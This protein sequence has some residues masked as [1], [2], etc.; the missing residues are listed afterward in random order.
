[1]KLSVDEKVSALRE[2]TKGAQD[3]FAA[4]VITEKQGMER[5]RPVYSGLSDS[6]IKLHLTGKMEIG[7]YPMMPDL[8]WPKVYW[9]CA[10]FDGKKEDTNWKR[11]VQ[12]ALEF[13]LDFDGCPCFV[14]LSRSGQGAHIRMLFKEAVPAWMARR[15]LQFWL[16][17]AGIIRT[18]DEEEYWDDLPPSF[19]R[20]I[21]PQDI[22]SSGLT[23]EGMRRPGNL[24]GA[25]LNGRHARSHGGTM[26]LDPYK[27]A[28]GNFE[29]DGKHW[30]HVM[31]ALEKRDWGEAQLVEA[32]QDCPDELSIAPPTFHRT[33]SGAIK[34]ALPVVPGDNRDLQYNVAFCEFFRYVRQ[35]GVPYP[36]WMALATQLHRFGDD[37]YDLWHQISSLDARYE[38]KDTDLKWEQT[39]DMHPIRCDTLVQLGWRCP[40]LRQP[41]CNGTKAPTY[42]ADSTDA[43]IL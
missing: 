39:A 35:P 8:E 31:N 20:L 25:P 21:P 5:W 1:M 19:D 16:E 38:P 2:L 14:N 11:D 36:L 23:F 33:E 15:W 26:P 7:T 17:E 9:I 40:H 30:E 13:L 34:R 27:V 22:L 42:F 6:T 18:D 32:I 4:Y 43:E 28:M 37:G 24:A 12:R 3:C 41:R 29:P 10:D